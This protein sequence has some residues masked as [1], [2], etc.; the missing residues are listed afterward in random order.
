MH[1]ILRIVCWFAF[2]LSVCLFLQS[3]AILF[4]LSKKKKNTILIQ[5]SYMERLI[6]FLF[7]SNNVFV[8]KGWHKRSI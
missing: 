2:V 1:F 7:P 8:L 6:I 5:E 4:R 3:S